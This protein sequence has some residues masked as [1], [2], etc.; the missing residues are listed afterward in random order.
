MRGS[1]GARD[2]R[3][4]RIMTAAQKVKT[5][6]VEINAKNYEVGDDYIT[7]AQIRHLGNIPADHR[8]YHEDPR[9][10]DDP[11]VTETSRIKLHNNKPEKFYSVSPSITGGRA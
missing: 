2:A 7:L 6:P 1:S 3:K 4:V 11:E 9:P 5:Y 8:V 10:Q